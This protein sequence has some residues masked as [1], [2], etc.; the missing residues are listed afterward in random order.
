MNVMVC[1][2]NFNLRRK[3]KKN[4]SAWAHLV[5]LCDLGKVM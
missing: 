3:K 4:N 1:E 2:L 5:A